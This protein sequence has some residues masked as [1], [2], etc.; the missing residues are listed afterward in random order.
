MTTEGQYH[1]L[2]EILDI[3]L[4][5]PVLGL[6]DGVSIGWCRL[7]HTYGQYDRALNRIE[8]AK[9]LDRPDVPAYVLRWLVG[10][11]LLHRLIPWQG[12]DFHPASFLVAERELPWTARANRWLQKHPN[13]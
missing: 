13:M 7:S 12:R 6:A 5:H 2:Q 3:C 4:R 1:D 10:H 11:E 9:R 8:V